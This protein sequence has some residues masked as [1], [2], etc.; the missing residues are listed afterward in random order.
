MV[1]KSIFTGKQLRKKIL[2]TLV[3][4]AVSQF[5]VR[6]P[7]YG[8]DTSYFKSVF[9]NGRIFGFA[10]MLTGG[11]LENLSLG[12]FGITS[13]I[14]ASIMLQLFCIVVPRLET[15]RR[16]GEYGRKWYQKA[17]YALTAVLTIGGSIAL[18]ISAAKMGLY[19]DNNVRSY[20]LSIAGWIIGGLII[21][22]LGKMVEDHG[23]G[24]GISLILACN[25]LYSIPEDLSIYYFETMEGVSLGMAARNGVVILAAVFVFVFIA[26]WLQYSEIRVPVR[27]SK[28][29]VDDVGY[30]PYIPIPASMANVYPVIYASTILSL[31]GI[32]STIFSYT[33]AGRGQAWQNIL[34]ICNSSNWYNP[35]HAWQSCGLLVYIGLL[36]VM[37]FYSSMMV[38]TPAEIADNMKKNGDTIEGVSPGKDT[39]IY[40]N[41]RRRVMSSVNVV[42]LAVLVIL[43]DLACAKAGIAQFS[44]VGTSMVIVVSTLKD[45]V[46]RLKGS[47]LAEGKMDNLFGK[48]DYHGIIKRN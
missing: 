38:F 35:E 33:G 32:L 4:L 7:A 13:Y 46:I 34:S 20:V 19:T 42:V 27:Q 11:S 39:E 17:E 22:T 18:A 30:C 47:I 16:D 26:V 15:I 10:S 9:G 25:I 29:Q 2:F 28:K 6:V 5:L 14:T 43:P 44:F 36:V 37:G 23:I 1:I 45:T 21:V 40:F 31:P 3:V 48:G 12:T 8:I 24:N 41:R